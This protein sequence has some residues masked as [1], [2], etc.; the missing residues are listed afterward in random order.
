MSFS[1]VRKTKEAHPALRLLMRLSEE[2][3]CK[4][5]CVFL[6]VDPRFP[7]VFIGLVKDCE[8]DERPRTHLPEV[9]SCLDR[10]VSGPRSRARD[11]G[12]G[13]CA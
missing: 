6:L 13:F 8:R 4:V 1:R 11:R 3:Y 2:H 10:E 7:C 9:G 12:L 5:L